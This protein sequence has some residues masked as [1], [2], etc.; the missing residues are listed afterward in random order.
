MSRILL[1]AVLVLSPPVNAEEPPLPSDPEPRAPL[2]APPE[3]SLE[4]ASEPPPPVPPPQV[5]TPPPW[6]P[7]RVLTGPSPAEI[8][9]LEESG[10]ARQRIGGA[11]MA[12][13]GTIAF[14]GSVLW[15]AG[16]W[17]CDDWSHHHQHPGGCGSSALTIAGTTTSLVGAAVLIPGI[18]VYAG[19]S[20]DVAQAR[21]WKRC[22][23]G[24]VSLKLNASPSSA[25]LALHAEVM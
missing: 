18:V 23:W 16:G 25:G 19:A 6:A 22:F 2:V 21:D 5:T 12:G 3:P 14:I 15:I 9:A 7:Y 11:L 20:K 17:D 13:G 24:P 8:Q 10:H 1:L 4:L